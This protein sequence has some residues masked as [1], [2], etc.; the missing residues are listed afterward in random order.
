[1]TIADAI[2]FREDIGGEE[3]IMQYNHTL[4]VQGG[5]RLRKLWGTDIMENPDGELTAAMV[6]HPIPSTARI[7]AHP[8]STS[9]CLMCRRRRTLESGSSSKSISW[10]RC[11]RRRH[12]RRS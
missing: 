3:R 10:T 11:L 4:A 12:L 6:G 1:M 2:K 5:R 9:L 7:S 8:R